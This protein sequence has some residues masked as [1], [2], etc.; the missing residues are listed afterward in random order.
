MFKKLISVGI[1]FL[2]IS[3]ISYSTF[4]GTTNSNISGPNITVNIGG[5]NSAFIDLQNLHILNNSS[6]PNTKIDMTWGNLIVGNTQTQQITT[7]TLDANTNGINGLDT[8]SLQNNQ[9]YYLFAIYN[10]SSVSSLL[11]LSN[12]S[13]IMPSGYVSARLVSSFFTDG[14]AH[15]YGQE[16]QDRNVRYLVSDGTFRALSGGTATSATVVSL[17]AYGIPPICIRVDLNISAQ[18]SSVSGFSSNQI[19]LAKHGSPSTIV[20]SVSSWGAGNS[21]QS[22]VPLSNFLTDNNQQIDYNVNGSPTTANIDVLGYYL[23]I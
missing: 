5:N 13:P 14:S 16:Q 21:V 8:G 9:Y 17:A 11:S 6:T 19:Y 3:L 18:W 12:T 2:V 23:P 7:L 4:A 15:F 1:L 20:L 22:S 10:G